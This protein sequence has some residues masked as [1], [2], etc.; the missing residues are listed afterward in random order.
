V[1]QLADLGAAVI[2]VAAR[3]DDA[4]DFPRRGFDGQTLHRNKQSI[5][6]ACGARA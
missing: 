4:G 1:R 6:P 5:T 2:Q 3:E